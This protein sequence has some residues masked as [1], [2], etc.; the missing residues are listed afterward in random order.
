VQRSGFVVEVFGGDVVLGYFAGAD[1]FDTGVGS[2]FCA[3]ED[4]GFIGVA[5][6]NQLLDAFRVREGGVAKLL[7]VAGLPGGVGTGLVAPFSPG[8]RHVDASCE[9]RCAADANGADVFARGRE[10]SQRRGGK[11]ESDFSKNSFRLLALSL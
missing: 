10:K 3:R 2:V 8:I 4:S 5:L 6:F 9:I 11:S 7:Q 1:L